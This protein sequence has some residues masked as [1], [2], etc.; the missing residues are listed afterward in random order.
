M[1]FDIRAEMLIEHHGVRN[2]RPIPFSIFVS[3]MEDMLN[4]PIGEE[5]DPGEKIN[6]LDQYDYC[7]GPVWSYVTDQILSKILAF[8]DKYYGVVGVGMKI[9]NI[10][11]CCR[12]LDKDFVYDLLFSDNGI[13]V[14]RLRQLFTMILRGM[15]AN[16]EPEDIELND[17]FDTTAGVVNEPVQTTTDSAPDVFFDPEADEQ[18]ELHDINTSFFNEEPATPQPVTTYVEEITSLPADFDW[19][20]NIDLTEFRVSDNIVGCIREVQALREMIDGKILELIPVTMSVVTNYTQ[21]YHKTITQHERYTRILNY[22]AR[23]R[24]LREKHIEITKDM[25][26]AIGR[27]MSGS[28]S[29]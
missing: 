13:T 11:S 18:E 28:I 17:T 3:T 24:E 2:G 8:T 23:I 1:K 25:Q 5:V 16:I 4:K 21:E 29:P 19:L 10:Q 20:A 27:W 6:H 15:L 14:G 12:M 22:N 9:Y 26:V 7:I